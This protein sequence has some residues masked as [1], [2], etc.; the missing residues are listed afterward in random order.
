MNPD[1]RS[2]TSRRQFLKA[3]GG[4]AAVSAL[5]GA[6]VPAVHAAGSEQVQVA[7]VGC[8]GRGSGAAL[9]A[10]STKSGPIKLIAMAD[11][12]AD[13][14]KASYGNLQ[15][16]VP[17]NMDVPESSRFIGWDAY[18]KAMDM[19]KPGDVVIL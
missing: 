12:F 1:D 18:Q 19:L 4:L 3:T 15:E 10:L 11:A 9:N 13:R 8:G 17:K 16:A 6:A 7:L 5:T 14:L 2:L